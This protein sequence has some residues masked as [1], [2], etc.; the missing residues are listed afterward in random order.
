VVA[1]QH[2]GKEMLAADKV[3]ILAVGAALEVLATQVTHLRVVMV[4]LE[5][6]HILHGV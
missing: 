6:Q 4:V 5:Y 1:L 2:L 3:I